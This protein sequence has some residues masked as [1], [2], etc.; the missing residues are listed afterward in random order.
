MIFFSFV[1]CL[2]ITPYLDVFDTHFQKYWA[3]KSWPEQ[4]SGIFFSDGTFFEDMNLVTMCSSD[5]SAY[6]LPSPVL[7]RTQYRLAKLF[8]HL[9]VEDRIAEGWRRRPRCMT[10]TFKDQLHEPMALT[11]FPIVTLGKISRWLIRGIWRLVPKVLR[12]SFYGYLLRSKAVAIT[13][14]VWQL[15]FG[16]MLKQ[17]RRNSENEANALKVVEKYTNIPTPLLVDSFRDEKE[18]LFMVT[19]TVRGECLNE[20]HHRM[21]YEERDRFVDDMKRYVAQLRGLPVIY[22]FANTIGGTIYDHCIREIKGGPFKDQA[23]FNKH[24]ASPLGKY[25]EPDVTYAHSLEHRCFFTH[26]DLHST[27]ILIEGGR[28]S[29]IIDWECA[30]Y[31]P[32]YWE[33]TKAMH[34]VFNRDSREDMWRRV[35]DHKYEAELKAERIL[36]ELSPF[37]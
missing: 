21:S 29:G 20:V 22:K 10:F 3:I 6:S 4:R 31:Y 14:T 15:P 24:I 33:F 2:D 23:E 17:C 37:G 28:I 11:T 30:G 35:F 27:N 25:E 26:A 12:V 16:L 36:W 32:E 34:G 9:Y 19:T 1:Y 5:P 7:L 18:E 13:G 8:H